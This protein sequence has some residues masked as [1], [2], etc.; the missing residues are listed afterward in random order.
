MVGNT[1]PLAFER[2]EK[3]KPKVGLFHYDDAAGISAMRALQTGSQPRATAACLEFLPKVRCSI[4]DAKTRTA[5]PAESCGE[6]LLCTLRAGKEYA[7]LLENGSDSPLEF[8]VSVDG[9]SVM[10]RRPASLQK[11]GYV[12]R[13]G[14]FQIIDGWRQRDRQQIRAFLATGNFSAREDR[15]RASVGVIGVAVFPAKT[16]PNIKENREAVLSAEEQTWLAY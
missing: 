12:V 2:T 13:A 16:W 14:T 5:Q 3:A 11:R 8:V 9:Q 10:D 4:L 6:Y 15:R 7:L 1:A